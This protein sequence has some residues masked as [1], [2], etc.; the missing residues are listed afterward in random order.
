[1]GAMSHEQ[2]IEITDPIDFGAELG[3]LHLVARAVAHDGALWLLGLEGTPDRHLEHGRF[4]FPRSAASREQTHVAIRVDERGAVERRAI[5]VARRNLHHIQ[6]LPGGRLI[7]ACARCYDEADG[8]PALNAVVVARDGS[9][10]TEFVIGDAVADLQATS[11]G[12]LWASYFDEGTGMRGRGELDPVGA[13]GLVAFDDKGTKLFSFDPTAAGTDDIVDC[14]A[15]NVAS[16][17]ETWIYFYRDFSL[18]RLSLE[19]RPRVWTTAIR[20]ARSIAVGRGHVLLDGGHDAHDRHLLCR[21][22]DRTID[23]TATFRF[24]DETGEP[25]GSAA[26]GRGASLH[27]VRGTRWYRA[28]LGTLL[29]EA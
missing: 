23:P 12:V 16:S 14:Y 22:G 10:E 13:S 20:G 9:I 11:N 15:L 1:M 29:N 2:R 7:V 27:F 6:P 19:G 3:D 5:A 28:D 26:H 24:T 25:L 17:T 21:L 4:R 18:V 8:S